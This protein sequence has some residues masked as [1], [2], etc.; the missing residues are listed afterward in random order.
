MK[1]K[2]ESIVKKGKMFALMG[3]MYLTMSCASSKFYLGPKVGLISPVSENEQ[4]YKLSP[5]IGGVCG[6]GGG[7]GGFE[8]GLDHFNSSGEYIETKSNLLK[9]NLNLNLAKPESK[10]KPYLS[11]GMNLLNE[12][13]TINIP[14]FNVRDE[15]KYKTFGVEF[16]T[17]LI[18][19]DRL[20]LGITY[21]IMPASENVPGMIAITG[22]YRISFGKK[23]KKSP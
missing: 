5:T 16:G 11:G 2:L 13:S 19:L 10:V 7:Q 22:G 17:G 1:Q 15:L 20:N 4:T 18:I 21:T 23:D 8:V 9:F 6:V 14:K 12:S 3:L